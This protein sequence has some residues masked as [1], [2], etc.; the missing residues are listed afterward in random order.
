M[1]VFKTITIRLSLLEQIDLFVFVNQPKQ[2]N[3][4]NANDRTYITVLTNIF[5]NIFRF[6]IN[7][8]QQLNLPLEQHLLD[9]YN[10]NGDLAFTYLI[11]S[12]TCK[13]F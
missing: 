11:G 6:V 13:G 5:D 2:M 4:L 3:Y 10:N 1:N 12:Q 7:Y 9:S 8:Y